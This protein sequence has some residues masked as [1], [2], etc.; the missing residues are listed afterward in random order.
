M[1]Q[2]WFGVAWALSGGSLPAC[3]G[4]LD[5]TKAWDSLKVLENPHKG[6]FHHYYDNGTWGY[7]IRKDSDLEAFPGM[8]HLFFRIAWSYLE[9]REG[10]YNW[11]LL[12]TLVD[13]WTPR[14]YQI[15]FAITCKE[16]GPGGTSTPVGIN[17]GYATPKWVAEAG[18]K[19]TL[20]QNWGNTNWEPVW[21][22][23]VFL[24]K[25]N[26]FHEAFSRR[27]DGKPWLVDMVTG[28]YGDWGEG[29]TGFSTGIV[30]AV[31]T[32]KKHMDIYARNYLKTQLVAGDEYVS[33]GRDPGQAAD[34]K[35]FAISK[36]FTFRDD[37]PLVDWYVQSL[38]ETF[39]VEHVDL[40][41]SVWRQK[42]VTIELDHYAEVK[43]RG[44]W[45]GANGAVKGG[46]ILRG[47]VGIAH[48]TYLGYHGY[49]DE[50]LSENPALAR[51]LANR[52][53]YWYF[54]HRSA[55]PD[56]VAAGGKASLSLTW[57]NRGVAPAYRKY[58]PQLR[59]QGAGSF[60]QHSLAEGS[61][62]NWMPDSRVVETYSFS[63]RA[64]LPPGVYQVR[65]RLVDEEQTPP[66]IVA[67]A[68]QDSLIDADGFYRIGSIRILKSGQAALFRSTQPSLRKGEHPA[69]KS[70]KWYDFIGR[71]RKIGPQV[72]N[73]SGRSLVQHD[74]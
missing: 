32:V 70:I 21:G 18:A 72:S 11:T 39:S 19:G 42:P 16:T 40:F 14:R 37:S 73:P 25:L 20:V 50:W 33:W 49:A 68:L 13:K 12:D 51:E 15:S 29:H 57:E 26:R 22:D 64:D 60:D 71:K 38:P 3:A 44:N 56:S 35:A 53:G 63:P 74:G 67:L 66:R 4:G 41:E 65:I 47:V 69:T 54:L 5:L 7:K 31:S 45:V 46:G 48:A 52:V 58:V 30:P 28:S 36:G 9:P 61:N 2:F 8:H 17:A 27:Y 23:S 59:L 55:F 43:K 6:W 62:L 10:E 1:K 34:L 24:D